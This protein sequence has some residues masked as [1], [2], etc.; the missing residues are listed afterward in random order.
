MKRVL[1]V[2]D[3]VNNMKLITFVLKKHGYEPIEAFSGDE[4]VEKAIA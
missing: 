4:G 3:N 1:V 2:E